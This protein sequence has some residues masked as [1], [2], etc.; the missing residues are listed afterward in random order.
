MQMKSLLLGTA[1]LLTLP[2]RG[3]NLS[4][5]VFIELAKKVNPAVVNIVTKQDV[6]DLPQRP[7]RRQQEQFRDPFFDLFERFLGPQ[8]LPPQESMGTGFVIREDGL[9]VTNNHVVEDATSIKVSFSDRKQENFTAKVI[10]RDARTDI[11]LI[12]IEG[13]KFPVVQLGK[14]ADLQVGEWVAAFG[15]PLGLGHTMTKGIVSAIGRE[16]GELNRLPFIQ[17]DASI[18]PGNSGGPLVNLKGQVI[19]VNSAIARGNGIGFAIPIDDVQFIIKKLEKD[20]KVLRGFIGVGFAELTD[21]AVKYFKLTTRQG[22]LVQSVMPDSPAEKAGIKPG[23]ILTR[24]DN[25][26][27]YSSQDLINAVADSEIGRTKTLELI[28]D[29]KKQT[30]KIAI[31]VHPEDEE[32][33][34]EEVSQGEQKTY[35]G[36]KAP[37]D[38]GFLIETLNETL[39]DRFQIEG[40][41]NR[42]VVIEVLPNSPA[43]EGGLMPGDVILSVN[44]KPVRTAQDVLKKLENGPNALVVDRQGGQLFV[45]VE[46]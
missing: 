18:N 24:L 30:V 40:H 4:T 41:A 10:G 13:K 36:Q 44:K 5:T 46:P 34:A 3:E 27:L 31:G 43:A 35:R 42:P 11:A 19:G 21:Q 8:G 26:E 6:P 1:F 32:G 7:R 25:K 28:R 37:F 23:D 22:V 17:T 12:K 33:R 38:L 15:N 29:G 20:G 9:I 14:S 39:M 2:V 45:F 16:I